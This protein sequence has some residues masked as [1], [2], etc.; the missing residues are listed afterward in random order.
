M[1][2]T[3]LRCDSYSSHSFLYDYSPA[4]AVDF[5]NG[6][7]SSTPINFAN[8]TSFASEVEVADYA[9]PILIM[10]LGIVSVVIFQIMLFFRCC[11]ACMKCG[12][13]TFNHNR[14]GW[15]NKIVKRRRLLYRLFYVFVV[16]ALIS[17]Q[18]TLYGSSEIDGAVENTQVAIL[19]LRDITSS[20][21]YNIGVINST[22]YR[23]DAQYATSACYGGTN[24]YTLMRLNLTNEPIESFISMTENFPD[25][26]TDAEVTLGEWG[27]TKK[28]SV[29]YV[30]YVFVLLICF[31]FFMSPLMQ[32]KKLLQLCIFISEVVIIALSIIFSLEMILLVSFILQITHC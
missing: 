4:P 8:V 31:L 30:F 18:I 26:L 16:T 14:E 9:I 28:N 29:V 17:D 12:P 20:S 5:T 15:Q 10:V 27:K 13:D 24:D 32:L 2:N 19:N 23:I 6:M 7:A 3:T 11:C 1:S 22:K 21:I 25:T